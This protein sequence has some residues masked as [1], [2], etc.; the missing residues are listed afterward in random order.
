MVIP[1]HRAHFVGSITLW[2]QSYRACESGSVTSITSRQH[3]E[4]I[5]RELWLR[6]SI[7]QPSSASRRFPIG[8]KYLFFFILEKIGCPD[9]GC[10]EPGPESFQL[11]HFETG[12]KT[13]GLGS[14]TGASF[15]WT[16]ESVVRFSSKEY[17]GFPGISS[18]IQRSLD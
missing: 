13:R 11:D 3:S 15:F 18:G 16:R 14:V 9:Y 10:R 12:S 8:N 7:C 5:G 1:E 6:E 2:P 4:W 17:R